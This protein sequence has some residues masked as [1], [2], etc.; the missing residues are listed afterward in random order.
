MAV[1]EKPIAGGGCRNEVKGLLVVCLF[2]FR[3]LKVRSEVKRRSESYGVVLMA[4]PI[5]LL[6]LIF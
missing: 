1:V 4:F 3:G 2:H 6:I 5:Y